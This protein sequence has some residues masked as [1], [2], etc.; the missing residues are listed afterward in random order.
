MAGTSDVEILSNDLFEED[1]AGHGSI[2]YLR[3]R[4]LGLQD[5]ELI[6][7]PSLSIGV[8]ERMREPTQPLPQQSIDLLGRQLVADLLSR[9]GISTRQHTVIESLEGDALLGQLAF[10][11]LVPVD[12]ELRV[13]REIAAELQEERTE[14]VIDAIEVVLVDHRGGIHEPRVRCAGRRIAS[15]L[16]PNN[17]CLLLRLADVEHAFV[18]GERAQIVLREFVLPFTGAELNEPKVVLLHVPLDGV[19]EA[20]G[21]RRHQRGRREL[22]SSMLAEE[23]GDPAGVLEFLDVDIEVHPIDAF[24]R[25]RDVLAKDLCDGAW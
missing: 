16:G 23:P 19:D 13:V 24:E 14:V 7:H 3:E 15:A 5:G 18:L 2:E 12:A 17:A 6:E 10:E 21:H 11:I 1:A 9:G 20:L 25:Q 22:H 8:R 4:K